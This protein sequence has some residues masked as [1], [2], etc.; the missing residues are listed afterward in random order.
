MHDGNV[1]HDAA[2]LIQLFSTSDNMNENIGLQP[3]KKGKRRTLVIGVVLAVVI[4]AAITT[5]I[6]YIYILG[7]RPA[8]PC[9]PVGEWGKCIV[10]GP[11]NVTIEFGEVSI[12]ANGVTPML[13]EILLERNGTTQNWYAFHDN[14][15][16]DL[17]LIEGYDGTVLT[18]EDQ[19]DNKRIDAGDEI[20]M[21]NLRPGS[22]YI[23]RMYW[24]PTGD[25]MASKSFSTPKG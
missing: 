15:D 10:H 17:I 21:K 12:G 14:S 24:V 9:G 5:T 19:A 3:P 8:A 20:H 23:I 1:L 4:V 25:L 11:T 7:L 2:W 22:E 6:L 13:L 18:Y 16:G